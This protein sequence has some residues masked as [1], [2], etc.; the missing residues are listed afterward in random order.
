M[1][2][3]DEAQKR[4]NERG[5]HESI[6]NSS[7]RLRTLSVENVAFHRKHRAVL[8]L[9]LNSL[10]AKSSSHDDNDVAVKLRTTLK[11]TENE[12]HREAAHE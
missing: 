3:C 4:E 6:R 9:H 8:Q 12:N 10:I 5:A 11:A 7:D 2:D 1:P